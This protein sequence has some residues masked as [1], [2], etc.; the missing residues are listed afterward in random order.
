MKINIDIKGTIGNDL[1]FT[2][3]TQWKDYKSGEIQGSKLEFVCT[4]RAFDKISIKVNKPIEKF[5]HIKPNSHIGLDDIENLT[6]TLYV[7]NGF[8]NI[9]WKA[10]SLKLPPEDKASLPKLN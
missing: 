3:V 4:E 1:I 2:A 5:M 9:S 8:V 10:D 7:Q 6:G